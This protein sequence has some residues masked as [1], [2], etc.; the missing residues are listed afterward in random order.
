MAQWK[1]AQFAEQK[2]ALID[3]AC[4]WLKSYSQY[5]SDLI[6]KHLDENFIDEFRKAMEE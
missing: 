1:D 3:K 5:R 4:D 6:A 2:Q